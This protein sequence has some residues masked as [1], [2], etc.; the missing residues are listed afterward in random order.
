MPLR[1]VHP[2]PA[3]MAPELATMSLEGLKPGAR[4]LDPMC[5]SGSV[6]RACVERGLQCVGIDSDPLAVLMSDV[7]TSQV[8]IGDLGT[9]ADQAVETARGLSRRDVAWPAGEAT[10]A[11][12]DFWFAAPQ[13][14]QLARLTTALARVEDR[15]VRRALL[16][17]LSR[18]IV[19]KDRG[20]SLARDVSH[21]RPH[22]VATTSD[23]DTFRAFAHSTRHVAGRLRPERI[24][25]ESIVRLGDA[26]RLMGLEDGSFDAA[27]TS[28]PYLNAIDYMRG[29]RLALVW[30]GHSVEDLR[31][32]RSESIGAERMLA[33]STV[34]VGPFIASDWNRKAQE[35]HIGWFRRYARDL[36]SVIYELGRVVAPGGQITL[37]VANSVIGGAT[38][39]NAG[40][41]GAIAKTAGLEAVEVR[42]RSIPAQRRY[43]PPPESG[44]GSLDARMKR[45][46]VMVLRRP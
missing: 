31:A 46:T 20:A 28:P 35:R 14:D 1:P 25:S 19:T 22:K 29:H 39:D 34:D 4:V 27:I 44:G 12:V 7:W 16:V 42:V 37:V 10:S 2:F 36:S 6:L 13:R 15:A 5:G 18:I 21:S 23:F 24:R 8:D 38:F 3:R 33:S 43:L 41:A 32:I 40:L 11:F 45:E 30:L 9:Q 17:A 26:R